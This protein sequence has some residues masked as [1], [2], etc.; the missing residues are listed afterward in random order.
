MNSQHMDGELRTS[1][2]S[3]CWTNLN[4]STST[5]KAQVRMQQDNTAVKLAY[6]RST[7]DKQG[8]RLLDKPKSFYFHDKSSGDILTLIQDTLLA[9][10]I[11][12]QCELRTSMALGCLKSQNSSTS[13][14]KN[15]II[16][17]RP[18]WMPCTC[19]HKGSIILKSSR[20]NHCP[21][22]LVFLCQQATSQ[23]TQQ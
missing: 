8:F 9:K 5:T 4:H 22:H 15:D 20:F 13:T 19:I 11:R 6:G 18:N 1:R 23:Y 12:H 21:W 14:T 7:Q 3:G 17:F 10:K 2:A 16:T